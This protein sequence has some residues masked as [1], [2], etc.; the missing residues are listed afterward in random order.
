[1]YLY[2]I[3]CPSLEVARNIGRTCIEEK[4]AGC[5][6]IIPQMESIYPWNGKIESSSEVILLLKTS[7]QERLKSELES[8]IK[9]LHPYE[10]P[11]LMGL[12]VASINGSYRDWL[13]ENLKG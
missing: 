3:P 13:Y 2:Y 8:R 9:A 1:M 12:A 4:L 10:V 7:N 6:N 11:C 5:A